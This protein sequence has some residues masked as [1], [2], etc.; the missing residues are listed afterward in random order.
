MRLFST[1]IVC[2]FWKTQRIILLRTV[3]FSF[4]FILRNDRFAT[5]TGWIKTP[6]RGLWRWN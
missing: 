5:F 3:P 6:K 2:R 1:G 4:V